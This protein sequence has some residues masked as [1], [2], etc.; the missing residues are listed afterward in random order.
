[1]KYYC[2]SDLSLLQQKVQGDINEKCMHIVYAGVWSQRLK[3]I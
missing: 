1:M 2:I 3:F